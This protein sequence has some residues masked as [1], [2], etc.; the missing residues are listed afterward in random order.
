MMPI[1]IGILVGAVL[2][3]VVKSDA[4]CFA[5]IAI[6]SVPY[7]LLTHNLLTRYW[8]KQDGEKR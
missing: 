1:A 8:R 2:R 5:L 6:V 7:G 4:L 3:S